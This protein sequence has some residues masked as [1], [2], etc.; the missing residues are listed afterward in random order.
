M[1]KLCELL[2]AESDVESASKK[3]TEEG[4]ITFTKKTN[5]FSG[6]TRELQLYD[7]DANLEFAPEI[8]KLDETVPSKLDYISQSV[9]RYW[10]LILQKEVT[11]QSA[12]ASIKIG[13][14]DLC[15]GAEFP[16]TFLL[17]LEKKLANLRVIYT[18]LPTLAP[19]KEWEK[20]ASLGEDT[21]KAKDPEI[22]FKTK[23]EVQH[24]ILDKATDKHPAQIER[25]TEDVKVGKYTKNLWSG[26]ITPA[27]KSEMLE[28]IDQLI[29]ATKQARMRANQAEVVK[30]KI[31][32]DLFDFING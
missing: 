2:A 24:K 27:R 26:A 17:G 19:G 23:K 18:R 21:W 6:S 32:K 30:D 5:L 25:W 16:A 8:D 1:S 4:L 28:K 20:D 22:T 29:V 31:G 12:R 3:I 9:T 14:A 7:G 10:D 13:D 11:N 15:G